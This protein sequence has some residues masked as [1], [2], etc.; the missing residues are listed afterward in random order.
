MKTTLPVSAVANRYAPAVTLY[1]PAVG[2]EATRVIGLPAASR[3]PRSPAQVPVPGTVGVIVKGVAGIDAPVT[4]LT[5]LY[6]LE[7]TVW[8]KNRLFITAPLNWPYLALP[9]IFIL[10]R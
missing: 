9:V 6:R 3:T 10:P 4:S 8:P 7:V 5:M 1:W 2:A